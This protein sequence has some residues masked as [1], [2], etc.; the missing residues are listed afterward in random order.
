[1]EA[2]VQRI[3]GLPA[4][5]K[6]WDDLQ[7]LVALGETLVD[8]AQHAEREGLVQRI[9][10]E[11]IER[12]LEGEAQGL[13]FGMRAERRGGQRAGDHAGADRSAHGSGKQG[14]SVHVLHLRVMIL[15]W[16][17]LHGKT[18]RKTPTK[19]EHHARVP[20]SGTAPDPHNAIDCIACRYDHFLETVPSRNRRM[21]RGV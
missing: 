17:L 12:T 19:P 6:A 9:G 8:V 1:M 2:P 18:R 13:A 5:G 16:L 11:R 3:D 21:D 10:I 7:I 15:F 20:Q 14:L 4:L